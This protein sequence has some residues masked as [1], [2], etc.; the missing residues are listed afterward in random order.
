MRYH[1]RSYEVE[2]A[3][4][5]GDNLDE[6]LELRCIFGVEDHDDKHLALT[7]W[8]HSL[9]FLAEGDWIVR[10][11]NGEIRQRTN[12]QFKKEYEPV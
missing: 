12:D 7:V 3:Q 1:L 5:K 8:P 11:P 9:M 2:A 4:W 10:H 6:L